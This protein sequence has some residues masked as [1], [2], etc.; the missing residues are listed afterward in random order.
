MSRVWTP[1]DYH[2][3]MVGHML[4]H[5]RN[6]VWA[7][8]GLGKTSGTLALLAG[9]DMAGEPGPTLVLGPLRVARDVWPAEVRKWENFEHLKVQPV[10]G[11]A[12]ERIVALRNDKADIYTMNYDNLP[13]LV[14]HLG[15]NWPFRNVIADEAIRLKNYRPK[16]GGKRTQALSQVAFTKVRR[17]VNLTGAPAPNGLKDLWGQTWFL[18]QGK[19]L[20]RTY[21]AFEER[22]FGYRRVRDAID[23]HKTNIQTVI[24]DHSQA[25]IEALLKDI[26]LTIDPKDWFDL[27]EPICRRVEVELRGEAWARYR[28]M[29]RD[30]FTELEGNEVEAFAAA[31]KTIKCLQLANGAAYVG[32]DNASW[33]ETHDEKIEAL[34]SILA[35]ACGEPVL[36]AYHFK[37]DLAR[38]LKAFP[39]GADLSTREGMARFMAGDAEVGFGH[40]A[41][42]GHGVD[43]LQAHCRI[44]CFWGHWWDYDQR[45]QFIARVGP[46]RQMQ[47]GKTDP[48]FIYD[49]V[50][51]DTVD[52]LVL[53]RHATKRSVQD[54]LLE[55]MKRKM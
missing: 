20:G 32:E 47:A 16:Q 14:D 28:E 34:R 26:C 25:E 30:M 7:G 46:V 23:A 1:R 44:A 13:W 36:T 53:Q 11:T 8:M 54:I 55:A 10:I 29:E 19:R 27:D 9:L 22:W 15:D 48:F 24:F 42:M 51:K 50:A 12:S 45:E 18:D 4:D 5:P 39:K 33:I 40:P 17:W 6:A 52:E 35:E 31:G 2:P 49:I 43:G 38:L 21:S 37:H 3:M 41:S